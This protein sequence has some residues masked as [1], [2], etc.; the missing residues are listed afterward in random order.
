MPLSATTTKALALDLG[1]AID[2][3]LQEGYRDGLAGEPEPGGNRSDWYRHGWLNGRDDRR[4]EPRQEAQATAPELLALA[5]RE[6][7]T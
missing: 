1:P 3:E 5:K 4:C 6:G 7:I 2:G